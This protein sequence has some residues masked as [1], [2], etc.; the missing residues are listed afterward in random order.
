VP[1]RNASPLGVS[2]WPRELNRL[3]ITRGD[4][5][6]STK[7][8]NAQHTETR[9]RGAADERYATEKAIGAG[10]HRQGAGRARLKHRT[11]SYFSPLV[12]NSTSVTVP[13]PSKATTSFF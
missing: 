10:V 3:P 11:P 7:P 5:P 2:C 12:L 8:E 1:F 4:G 9:G 13:S 6:G